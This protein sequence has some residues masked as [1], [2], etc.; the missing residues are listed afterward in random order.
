MIRFDNIT[1]KVHRQIL[2]DGATLH[3]SSGEKVVVRGASGCG[4]SSLL[5]ST[6]GAI[7]LATGS[8]CADGVALS[9]ETVSG[10]R[11]RIAFIGQEPVLGA[12][13]VR[14]A[15]LLPFTFK[16]HSANPPSEDRILELLERLHLPN[17]ILEKPCK[18]ISGGEKQR[19]AILRALLLDK[20]AKSSASPSSAPCCSTK[21]SSSP[22]R[23]HRPSTPKAARR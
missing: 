16:V 14:E 7:P 12:E 1:L 23:S 10:I 4:K 21:P 3:I 19:I 11:A 15:I 2:L 6:V 20:T 18:R 17:T 5:K 9:P 13:H 8:V 22:T